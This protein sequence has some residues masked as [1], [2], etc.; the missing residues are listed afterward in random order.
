MDCSCL[1]VEFRQLHV[2]I[3][4]LV[5]I[6][7]KTK[8]GFLLLYTDSNG[9]LTLIQ[10]LNNDLIENVLEFRS[11]GIGKLIEVAEAGLAHQGLL[12]CR[13]VSIDG[14]EMRHYHML[15]IVFLDS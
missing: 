7:V 15:E 14:L 1:F 8:T 11:N 3:S 9:C 2:Q 6:T 5:T 10:N 13:E 12:F 4:I